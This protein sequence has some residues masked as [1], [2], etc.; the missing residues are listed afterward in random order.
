M[1]HKDKSEI[2]YT[3]NIV[4]RFTLNGQNLSKSQLKHKKNQNQIPVSD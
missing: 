4:K 2:T 1:T 3:E